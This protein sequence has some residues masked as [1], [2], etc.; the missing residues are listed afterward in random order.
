M[1]KRMMTAGVLVLAACGADDSTAPGPMETP[2]AAVAAVANSWIKRA[3]Y[4]GTIYDAADAVTTN[5]SNQSTLYIIGGKTKSALGEGSITDAVKAYNTAT[6]TWTSKAHLPRPIRLSNGA[7]VLDGK[8]YLTGGFTKRLNPETGFYDA[9]TLKSLY[10]YNP[11][12]NA[13]TRKRDMPIPTINGVSGAFG[14]KLYVVTACYTRSYCGET[15][16]RGALFRYNPANDNWVLL[17]RTPHDPWGGAAHHRLEAVPG[18]RPRHGGRVRRHDEHLVHRPGASRW[19]LSSGLCH[20]PGEAVPGRVFRGRRW[21]SDSD[22][23]V[24]SRGSCLEPGG[25]AAGDSALLLDAE[26]RGR[27]RQP[28]AGAGGRTAAQQLAIHALVPRDQGRNVGQPDHI[29]ANP[30]V[31][32]RRSGGRGPAK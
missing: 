9:E 17:T 22:A 31:A 14:G 26:P 15:F 23:G 29:L 6:N 25:G 10:V 24:Q 5:A 8:I 18:H 32:I 12:T 27:S 11:G 16:S 20:A 3:D 21:R 13:W 19:F 4:P 7:V 28:E 30:I 2:S 1:N